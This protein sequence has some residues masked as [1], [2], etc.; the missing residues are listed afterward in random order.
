MEKDLFP[1]IL[2][3]ENSCSQKILVP[4]N[5]CSQKILVPENS[6]LQKIL[7]HR[8]FLFP[9]ILVHRKFLFPKILVPENS[10]SQKILLVWISVYS[11]ERLLVVYPCLV[12]WQRFLIP[13][14]IIYFLSLKCYQNNGPS[15]LLLNWITLLGRTQ[16]DK[17]WPQGVSLYAIVQH[18]TACVSLFIRWRKVILFQLTFKPEQCNCRRSHVCMKTRN[19]HVSSLQRSI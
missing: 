11:D 10:C 1:K 6:C 15:L 12:I 8:K 19:V 9:K 14:T 5:S 7:V 18:P 3:P 16:E 4:E 17:W 13:A 2:V